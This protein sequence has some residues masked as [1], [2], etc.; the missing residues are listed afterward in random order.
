MWIIDVDHINEIMNDLPDEVTINREGVHSNDFDPIMFMEMDRVPW[1]VLDDDGE[2]YYEGRMS[3]KRL[4]SHAEL[5]FG[6]LDFAMADAGA[7][8]MEYVKDGK[9]E[10][11]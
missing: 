9:W 8:T 11:L 2:V 10:V 7:T 6:P 1:R 4:E 3:K 5:A